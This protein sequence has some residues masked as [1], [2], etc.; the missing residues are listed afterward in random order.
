MISLSP[1]EAARNYGVSITG[2]V[3][4][5]NP[6]AKF[7]FVSDSSGSVRV[8]C[9]RDG[10]VP[11]MQ[12]FVKLTGVS[13]A[14]AYSPAILAD[15][16]Q[17]VS[18]AG[19]TDPVAVSLEQAMTGVLEN[20]WVS[21]EGLIQNIKPDGPWAEINILTSGGEFVSVVPWDAAVAQ[22]A[23]DVV[24]L[25]GACTAVPDEQRQLTGI[26]LWVPSVSEIVVKKLP[27]LFG[28]PQRSI[29]SLRRFSTV[30]QLNRRVHVAGTVIH[31]SSAKDLSV[32]DG[33]ST[34]RIYQQKEGKFI[35]GDVV[36]AVRI[37]SARGGFGDSAGG[38]R[39][40]NVLWG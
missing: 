22:L 28:I 15:S 11:A 1:E 6:A 3:T 7:F 39:A 9:A 21:L 14:G 37:S 12:E 30:K 18:P 17:H 16:I 13:V 8:N 25:T 4:W 33:S 10:S 23:G 24:R 20:N 34:L 2:A 5:S 40:Q 19:V 27:R 31:A 36:E 35:L 26:K 32:Q 29:S 38:G